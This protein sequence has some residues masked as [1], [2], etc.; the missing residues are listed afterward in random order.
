MDSQ[1]LVLN[2]S[3][4]SKFMKFNFLLGQTIMRKLSQSADQPM[5]L[6]YGGK[7]F[8]D[9]QNQVFYITVWILICPRQKV[10]NSKPW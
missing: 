8:Q 9:Q 6:F 2:A 3:S 10:A 1:I 4:C 7:Y 5:D